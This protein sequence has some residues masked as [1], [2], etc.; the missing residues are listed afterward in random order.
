MLDKK[1]PIPTERTSGMRLKPGINA[2][3]MEAVV[4]SGQS[5]EL[6]PMHSVMEAHHTKRGVLR[7]RILAECEI[8]IR[9]MINLAPNK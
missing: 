6:F 5:P 9:Q 8:I 2:H 1:N 4:A 7:L 3:K